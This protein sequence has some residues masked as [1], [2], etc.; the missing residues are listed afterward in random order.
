MRLQLYI[1]TI[2]PMRSLGK[3]SGLQVTQLQNIIKNGS[4]RKA[5]IKKITEATGG[6]VSGVDLLDQAIESLQNRREKA[7]REKLTWAS[8]F[9]KMSE[10]NVE[11]YLLE[12][13]QELLK[14][15][16]Q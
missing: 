13:E 15:L 10:E 4:T 3:R 5:T 12:Y 6:V 1:Q 14:K 2:E 8:Q 16:Q 9:Y 11:K 7:Y